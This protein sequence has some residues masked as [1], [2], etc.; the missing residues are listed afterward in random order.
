MHI[1]QCFIFG[2]RKGMKK[3]IVICSPVVTFLAS[4]LEQRVTNNYSESNT[5]DIKATYVQYPDNAYYYTADRK[6]R[7]FN[8]LNMK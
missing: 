1:T 2:H 5:I 4:P 3:R 6:A 7:T 8:V